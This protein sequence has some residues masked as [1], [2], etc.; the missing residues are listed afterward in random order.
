MYDV[1]SEMFQADNSN[2]SLKVTADLGVNSK[3]RR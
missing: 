2:L 3:K 1:A